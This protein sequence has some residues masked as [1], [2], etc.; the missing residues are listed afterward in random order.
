MATPRVPSDEDRLELPCGETV[1]VHTFDMGRRE[2]ACQ[3]GETHA[4]VMDIHP[5]TRFLPTFLVDTL[6]ETVEPSGDADE[7]GTPHL[8]GI[9][10][11][12]FPDDV[13]AKDV[14]DDGA[15]GCGLLWVTDFDSRRL[16]EIV[17]ELVVELMEHAISHAEDETARDAFEED[18]REFDVAAFVDAY[19]ADRDFDGERDTP[20]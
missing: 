10:L 4:L 1:D 15:I 18:M 17:V 7:F 16:H 3:C 19:R 6:S 13:V 8:M 20:V 5:L 11:E 12:E 9:V 2:F 14:E